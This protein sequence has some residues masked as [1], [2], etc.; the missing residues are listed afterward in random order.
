MEYVTWYAKTILVT[1]KIQ[2]RKNMDPK[3]TCTI[4]PIG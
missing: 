1:K 3:Q 4:E 2:N